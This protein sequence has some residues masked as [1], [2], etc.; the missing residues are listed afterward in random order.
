MVAC[1]IA[2]HEVSEEAMGRDR[3]FTLPCIKHSVAETIAVMEK[4]AGEKGIE[5]GP[6]ID[7]PDPFIQNIVATWPCDTHA[8]R[9]LA[10]GIPKPS[11]LEQIIE[12]YVEDFLNS[13]S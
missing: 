3:V 4:I 12:G 8:D 2:L 5:L 10:V 7:K 13:A 1:F 11:S 9:A 6:V